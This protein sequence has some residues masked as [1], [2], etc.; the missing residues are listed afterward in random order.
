MCVQR[1]QPVDYTYMHEVQTDITPEMRAIMV[2]WLVEVA[3]E[4]RLTPLTLHLCVKFIDRCLRMMPMARS[5]LQLLG[6]ACMLIA[7]YV[8]RVAACGAWALAPCMS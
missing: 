8:V 7:A 4:Y 2:D 1:E 6:C 5:K 3:Q